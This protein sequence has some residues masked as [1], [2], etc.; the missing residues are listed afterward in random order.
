MVVEDCVFVSDGDGVMVEVVWVEIV[1]KIRDVYSTTFFSVECFSY[2]VF[3][4]TG[5][6]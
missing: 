1:G 3:C 2:S 5:T 4:V 6:F